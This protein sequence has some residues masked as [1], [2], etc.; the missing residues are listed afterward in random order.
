MRLRGEM[1][2]GEENVDASENG[3]RSDP[4]IQK[5]ATAQRQEIQC[6]PDFRGKVAILMIEM[7]DVQEMT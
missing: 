4:P 7:G 5:S 2:V 1:H 3:V 6:K